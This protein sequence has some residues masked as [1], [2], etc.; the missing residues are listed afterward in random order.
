MVLVGSFFLMII[1]SIHGKTFLLL[2]LPL[3]IIIIHKG[4]KKR[5][6][7]SNSSSL[8]TAD[9]AIKSWAE[10]RSKASQLCAK[11]KA[12]GEHKKKEEGDYCY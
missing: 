5:R 2:L 6:R 10:D 12:G 3:T 4:Y 9:I 11:T 7:M 1:A 8:W